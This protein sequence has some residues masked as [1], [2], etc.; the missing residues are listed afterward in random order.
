M[1]FFIY[2][3]ISR[4]FEVSCDTNLIA[5]KNFTVPKIWL[6]GVKE[7]QLTWHNMVKMFFKKNILKICL[8]F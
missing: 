1:A 2:L 3:F 4:V 5:F 6:I 8:S 7:G